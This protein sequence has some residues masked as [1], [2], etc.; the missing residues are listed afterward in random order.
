MKSTFLQ[1]NSGKTIKNQSYRNND[2]KFRIYLDR[3]Q[4]IKFLNNTLSAHD[5][6]IRI[7]PETKGKIEVYQRITLGLNINGD[8]DYCELKNPLYVS[9]WDK[10]EIKNDLVSVYKYSNDEI[11]ITPEISVKDLKSK[12]KTEC[13]DYH[14]SLTDH[15]NQLED[16]SSLVQ[17][18]EVMLKVNFTN[19][20]SKETTTEYIIFVIANGC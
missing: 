15:I 17:P 3:D 9:K 12:I 11:T 16:I 4:S 18:R 7:I 14:L 20:E 5:H 8:G 6:I 19:T 1:E 13:G 2:D 10:L